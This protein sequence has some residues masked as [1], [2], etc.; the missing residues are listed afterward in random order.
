MVG[1][2]GGGLHKHMEVQAGDSC[3]PLRGRPRPSPSARARTRT[4]TCSFPGGTQ[5]PRQHVGP[6]EKAPSSSEV[7]DPRDTGL[8]HL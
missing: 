5:V 1:G 8:G 7:W 6:A 4:R 3:S 2:G